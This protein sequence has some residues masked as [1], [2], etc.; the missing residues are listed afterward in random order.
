MPTC[1]PVV[2]S[3]GDSRAAALHHLTLGHARPSLPS[4]AQLHNTER[5]T[6]VGLKGCRTL[7]KQAQIITLSPSKVA[8]DISLRDA[9]EHGSGQTW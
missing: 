5:E 4:H 7:R 2:S 9:L 6:F 3:G 1:S 8:A